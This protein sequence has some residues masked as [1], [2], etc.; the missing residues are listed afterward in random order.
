MLYRRAS[1]PRNIR[2]RGLHTR[3]IFD[4]TVNQQMTLVALD[5]DLDS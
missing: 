5:L 4:F 2:R 3:I 1:G